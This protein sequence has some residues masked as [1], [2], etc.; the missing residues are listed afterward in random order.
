MNAVV[1]NMMSSDQVTL[2]AVLMSC[3]IDP[4]GKAKCARCGRHRRDHRDGGIFEM[5]HDGSVLLCVEFVP[6]NSITGGEA[7]P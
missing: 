3:D 7:V 5:R 4:V 1:R 6:N 2:N